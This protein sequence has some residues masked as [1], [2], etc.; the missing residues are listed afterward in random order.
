MLLC[1]L[2]G[3]RGQALYAL[4]VQDIKLYPNKCAILF[5]GKHKHTKPGVHT[6]PATIMSFPINDKLCLVK[7]L[8]RYLE[9]TEELRKGSKLFISYI[10]PYDP[11]SRGTFSRWVKQVLEAA[12]LDT[13]QY[14]SHS[15]RAASTSAAA[16]HGASLVS[17]MKAAGWSNQRTFCK[18]YKKSVA[19]NFG[20][21][22]LDTYLTKQ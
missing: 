8:H 6:E 7:H 5:S 12:G 15:T 16:S 18:Y 21:S 11:I 3:Q 19:P 22:V 14:G 13:V 4:D 1:L 17:I 9:I 20:Q 10:K 2:T